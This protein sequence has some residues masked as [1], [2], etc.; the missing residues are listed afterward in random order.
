V[1][2]VPG[3]EPPIRRSSNSRLQIIHKIEELSDSD[4]IETPAKPLSRTEDD[5]MEAMD[6]VCRAF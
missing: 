4:E 2:E 5:H 1:R 3:A 6:R